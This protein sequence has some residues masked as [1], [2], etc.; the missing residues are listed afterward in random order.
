MNM[1]DKDTELY[2]ASIAPFDEEYIKTNYEKQWPNM[3]SISE[4]PYLEEREAH[5][6]QRDTDSYTSSLSLATGE[7]GLTGGTRLSLTPE[8]RIPKK[9]KIL[10]SLALSPFLP[11]NKILLNK[12]ND[13]N[14]ETTDTSRSE[15]DDMSH[16]S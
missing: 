13:N 8:K 12:E 14:P 2:T 6:H 9:K 15:K 3:I 4:A 16:T 10:K 1:K 11:G 7:T 5:K